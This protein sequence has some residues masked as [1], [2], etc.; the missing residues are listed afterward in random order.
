MRRDVLQNAGIKA[1]LEKFIYYE[2]KR[3][4]INNIR[5]ATTHTKKKFT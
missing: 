4:E 1:N 5:N 2:K 3:Q